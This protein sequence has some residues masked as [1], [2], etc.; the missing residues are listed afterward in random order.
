MDLSAAALPVSPIPGATVSRRCPMVE[1]APDTN[2]ANRGT[3]TL[4]PDSPPIGRFIVYNR[5]HEQ[6]ADPGVELR[7]QSGSIRRSLDDPKNELPM[8]ALSRIRRVGHVTSTEHHGLTG[9]CGSKFHATG[10]LPWK[11]CAR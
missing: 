9:R 2:D 10:G 6:P 8:D 11:A 4:V 7:E 3:Y 5:D 1:E